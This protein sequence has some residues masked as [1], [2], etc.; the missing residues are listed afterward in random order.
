MLS[1]TYGVLADLRRE[2]SDTKAAVAERGLL[3]LNCGTF[4]NVIRWIPPLDVTVPEIE[5]A[6][7]LF[8]VA[9]EG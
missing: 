2:L 3:V 6:L 1:R 4:D 8:Q 5:E 9:L 7:R